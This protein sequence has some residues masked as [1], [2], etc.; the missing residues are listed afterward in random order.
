MQTKM[1]PPTRLSRSLLSSRSSRIVA[2]SLSLRL[3][4]VG[5]T[6]R[7]CRL[8]LTVRRQTVRPVL[9]IG[10][11]F[12]LRCHDSGSHRSDDEIPLLVVVGPRPQR[13]LINHV[14][15]RREPFTSL[16]EADEASLLFPTSATG[17]ID[18]RFISSP[19]T[20][21]LGVA[22]LHATT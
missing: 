14:I 19:R 4:L 20:S 8:S 15:E 12:C 7:R 2:L 11:S 13:G 16:A 17:R 3:T 18:R 6:K 21:F 1:A 5:Y 9:G 10:R 22:R